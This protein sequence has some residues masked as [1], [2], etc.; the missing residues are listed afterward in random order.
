MLSFITQPLLVRQISFCIDREGSATMENCP[1][2]LE[3]LRFIEISSVIR[4]IEFYKVSFS[5]K[6]LY[7]GIILFVNGTQE[8]AGKI[9]VICCLFFHRGR[10]N[11]VYT[12]R[13]WGRTMASGGT[14][15][16]RRL[17]PA[18]ESDSHS[19]WVGRLRYV[20]TTIKIVRQRVKL[21]SVVCV[22]VGSM[23]VVKV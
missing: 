23:Q 6:L 11:R 20:A 21:Y 14:Q 12:Y 2:D 22:M 8:G 16:K 4:S 19:C 9:L 17:K 18:A 13:Q 1:Q 5:L 7:R 15:T 10:H 3:I